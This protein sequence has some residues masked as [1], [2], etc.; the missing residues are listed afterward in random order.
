MDLWLLDLETLHWTR[1][2]SMPVHALVKRAGPVWTADG[3]LAL[4]GYFG[5]EPRPDHVLVVWQ[6]GR[7]E[8]QFRAVS[9]DARY[10]LA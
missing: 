8:L 10:V 6:P 3:R 5:N 1:A 2:P 9:E 7:A 4:V